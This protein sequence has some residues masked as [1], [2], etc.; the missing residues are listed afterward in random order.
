MTQGYPV[1]HVQLVACNEFIFIIQKIKTKPEK[2]L[3]M[4]YF[5]KLFKVFHLF[6]FQ[7]GLEDVPSFNLSTSI[8]ILWK[9]E[10]QSLPTESC[11]PGILWSINVLLSPEET[12]HLTRAPVRHD[13]ESLY[14]IMIV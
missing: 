7:S 3:Y 12:I 14:F 2:R 11:F 9:S 1:H 5:Q 8:L 6:E 4:I 10:N 13:L